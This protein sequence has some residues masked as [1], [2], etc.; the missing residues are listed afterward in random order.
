VAANVLSTQMCVTTENERNEGL[1]GDLNEWNG[2]G[3]GVNQTNR[4]K[5]RN[6]RI[7]CSVNGK[8]PVDVL[9]VNPNEL[10]PFT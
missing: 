5:S 10:P 9:I 8:G 1:R 4:Y 7:S 6:S 3:R 2:C